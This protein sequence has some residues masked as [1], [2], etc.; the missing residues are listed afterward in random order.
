[1]WMWGRMT[2]GEG[3]DCYLQ[4]QWLCMKTAV[5]SAGAEEFHG[6]LQMKQGKEWKDAHG[7]RGGRG[8]NKGNREGV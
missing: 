8:E 5:G 6:L 7:G 1:M 2:R 4:L 3:I